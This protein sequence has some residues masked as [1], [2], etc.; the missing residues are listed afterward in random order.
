MTGDKGKPV[1]RLMRFIETFDCAR[2]PML[3]HI[4]EFIGGKRYNRRWRRREAKR[5]MEA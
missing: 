2:P 3:R 1:K 5:A 4:P